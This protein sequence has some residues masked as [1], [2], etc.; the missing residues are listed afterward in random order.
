MKKKSLRVLFAVRSYRH[1]PQFRKMIEIL[2]ERGH[3]VLVLIYK[4]LTD[5]S[6]EQVRNLEQGYERVT[7]DWTRPASRE[8]TF[9]LHARELLNFRK[10]LIT[11]GS[12]YYAQ[13]WKEY[14]HPQL[15]K[16]FDWWFARLLLKT[17]LAGWAL[18]L[19]E[20]LTPPKSA[21][22][23][24]LK[25]WKSDVVVASPVNLRLSSPELEYLKAAISL[26]IPT[27]IPMASWDN[28]TTKG[29]YHVKPDR[30]LVW[31]N[32][33]IREIKQHHN[34]NPNQ[35]R[36]IGA[37]T[38]DY[39]HPMPTP[40]ERTVFCKQH[41]IKENEPFLLYLG[42]SVNTAGDQERWLVEKI[43]KT[44]DETPNLHLK[45]LQL[46][47]RPHP[48]HFKIYQ[49]MD[50]PK[51]VVAPK[52]GYLPNPKDEQRLLMDSIFHSVGIIGINTSAMLDAMV[53]NRPVIAV[54]MGERATMQMETYHFPEL[55]KSKAIKLVDVKN[56]GEISKAIQN[57]LEGID[58]CKAMRDC[59][60]KEYIRPR[61]LEITSG[62]AIA[63]ELE[64]LVAEK[65]KVFS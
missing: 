22:L 61:G 7:Y 45:N 42:S 57:V 62:E 5:E 8:G 33:Q 14:L 55:V 27:A 58:E 9:L 59:F 1:L 23:V 48:K 54:N 51:I 10:H 21:V 2:A 36:V 30:Y 44:L 53:L 64:A 15:I 19:F 34:V 11:G 32:V 4:G 46:L 41:G 65:T 25:E 6:L 26:K 24:H 39:W 43:R 17:S 16:L 13:R 63:D 20:K 56:P 28:I 52:N 60:V 31:N 18:G 49:D 35:T 50:L 3:T 47:V 12:E 40:T 37:T 29:L 38:M